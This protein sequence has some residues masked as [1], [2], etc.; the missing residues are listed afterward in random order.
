MEHTNLLNETIRLQYLGLHSRAYNKFRELL[1]G[2]SQI[3]GVLQPELINMGPSFYRMRAF[4]DRIGISYRDMFH[5]PLDKRGIVKTQRYSILGYPCLYLG[6]SVYA[7]WEEMRRPPLDTCMVSRFEQSR[8]E[9]LRFI[10]LTIP[11]Y[12]TF[13]NNFQFGLILQRYSKPPNHYPSLRATCRSQVYPH[14]L[15]LHPA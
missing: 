5:I 14:P 13:E 7:C 6:C 2:K 9:T 12:E 3:I 15:S 1:I 10:D 4:T 11:E 8:P